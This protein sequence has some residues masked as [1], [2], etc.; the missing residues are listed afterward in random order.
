MLNDLYYI[1]HSWLIRAYGNANQD[2]LWAALQAQATQEG[3]SL[4]A[5][6]KDIMDT[7]TYKMGYPVITVT[8]DYQTGDAFVTQVSQITQKSI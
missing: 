7:W 3:V 6:V 1:M 5:T 4:P 2:D 8:R